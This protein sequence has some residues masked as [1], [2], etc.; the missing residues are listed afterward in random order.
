LYY[1]IYARSSELFLFV[2]PGPGY[3]SFFDFLSGGYLIVKVLMGIGKNPLS[4][5]FQKGDFPAQRRTI[6]QSNNSTY[7]LDC[8]EDKGQVGGESK[9]LP[10]MK[11]GDRNRD[12]KGPSRADHPVE[13]R[14][15]E[16][17]TRLIYPVKG[18][19]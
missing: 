14:D 11:G 7:V 8:Q 19:Q 17:R 10:L 5:P 13:R 4:P 1:V 2:F 16:V 15:P 12:G 9:T 6:V 3:D 18:I